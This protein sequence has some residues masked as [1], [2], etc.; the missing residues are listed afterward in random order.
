MHYTTMSDLIDLQNEH[1]V[2]S[3]EEARVPE[4]AKSFISQMEDI[5]KEK[6][7]SGAV[8]VLLSGNLGAGKTTFSKQVAKILGVAEVVTSP[9]FVILKRYS[10]T[11]TQIKN[12]IH[13]D[14]YRLENGQELSTL[15]FESLKK[16]PN[17][18][19][20]LEWPER[21]PE[22]TTDFDIKIIFEVEG[23]KRRKVT[24]TLRG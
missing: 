3:I 16:E 5:Y 22:V 8:L 14:A 21:V 2:C 4:L 1:S 24:V 9:T 7:S 13:I 19:I 17:T 20:L 15:G 12:V 10:T 18:L 11:H 23:E 6:L